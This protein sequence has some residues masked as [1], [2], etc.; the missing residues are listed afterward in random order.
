MNKQEPRAD[1]T[2]LFPPELALDSGRPKN[3]LHGRDVDSDRLSLELD[4]FGAATLTG[5]LS[6]AE[7]AELA[8]LYAD[9]GRFRSRVVMARHGFGR[10]EYKYFNYPLPGL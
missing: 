4:Q 9:E 5:L 1:A 7:C 2:R 3:A 6:G 8:G 10:G